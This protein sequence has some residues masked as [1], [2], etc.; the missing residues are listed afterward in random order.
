MKVIAVSRSYGS[1]GSQL[2]RQLA[3]RLG[4]DY[5]DGASIK[6]I[7]ESVETSS[8]LLASIEDEVG[9]G[10]LEK[11][12]S[13]M[14]NRSFY[15]T[16]LSLCLYELALKS[17]IVIVG[18][19]SHL[20]FAN[21]PSLLSLQVVRKLSERVKAVAHDRKLKMDDAL[22]LVEN[23]DKEKSKFTRNYFDK[24]L[25]DPLMF[26]MVINLSLVLM[27]QAVQ[28]V[29]QFGTATFESADLD[30]SRTWL[31]NRLLEK[32]AE[33]VLFHLGLTQ[34]P[35]VDFEADSGRLAVKGVIGGK[36]EK[37][38]LLEALAKLSE[39]TTVTDELRV[40]VLSRMLY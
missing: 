26:H 1:G 24:E 40:E 31:K 3:D 13:L 28:V 8:S 17:D 29:S 10:F 6:G 22:E 4:Y 5:A 30:L 11:L 23:K 37:Q 16:A 19:G 15:K 34:G 21:Y 36:H 12:T 33:M 38:Q 7:E 20:V 39:V 9:P 18:A 25:F 14:N 32:K 27:E 35:T 2:A